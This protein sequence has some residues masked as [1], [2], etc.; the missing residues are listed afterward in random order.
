VDTSRFSGS[1]IG[2]LVAI[3]GID[4]RSQR[5]FAH[6]AFVAAPLGEEPALDSGTW[7]AVTRATRALARLDQA[8]RQVPTPGLLRRPS[9]NREAQ[10]TSA[11]EGTY[12][13]LEQVLAADATDAKPSKELTEVLNYI[14]A[15][16]MAFD[17]V[18]ER[19]SL[20]VGVLEQ[21]QGILVRNTESENRD[22]GRIRTSLVAIGSPTGS[23]EDSRF[24]PMPPGTELEVAVR[25]WVDWIMRG[26]RDDRE[27]LVAAGLAHY[28]FETLHPFSD[29]NGRI[30][31]LAIV[32]Q[33]MLD[34]LLQEPLLTVSPWFE[35]RRGEY[36][37]HLASVSATGDWNP[38]IRFFAAGIESASNDTAQRVDRLIALQAEY[39]RLVLSHNGRGLVRDIVDTLIADPFVTIP[40]LSRRFGK[41]PAATT[42]AVE[43]LVEWGVLTGPVGTY[44]RQFFA[45]DVI[46]AVAAGVGAVPSRDE[47]L[48]ARPRRE[49]A[50]PTMDA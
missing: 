6:S 23:I 30:G 41:T 47:P 9:L 25:D 29:G 24:V 15:A 14:N 39:V 38:W 18:A 7:R 43:R 27:P 2:H 35:A 34:G 46:Q 37:E 21:A 10:S 19:R 8:S 1:P 26:V 48:I 11:L 3:N 44:N 40:R 42:T 16:N 33:F 20:N 36:Q 5:A 12:A 22:A 32:L 50:T 31:R 49:D 17:F 4:G 45:A 28:Q 13:P